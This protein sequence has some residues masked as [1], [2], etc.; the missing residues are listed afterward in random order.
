MS[1]HHTSAALRPEARAFAP[2][3]LP[4]S[5]AP[6]ATQLTMT[7]DL[8]VRRRRLRHRSRYTGMKETD[9]L[10][11]RFADRRIAQLSPSDLDAYERLLGA[12]DPLIFAW[13]TGQEPVPAE[14]DTPVFRSL[15]QFHRTA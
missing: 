11:G 3:F 8:D 6:F 9:L 15:V 1:R 4:L 2:R 13:V 7:E 12:G 14:H 10:L 5:S